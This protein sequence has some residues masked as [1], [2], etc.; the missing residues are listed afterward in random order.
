MERTDLEQWR[1]KE[2]ARL[3]ALVETERRYYQEMV[4]TLPVPLVV[5]AADNSIVSANRSFR[6]TFGFRTDDLRNKRIGELVPVEGI[7]EKIREAHAQGSAPPVFPGRLGERVLRVAVV[8][9]RNWDD[10]S[11]VE[12]LL[13]L[14][15]VSG[16]PGVAAAPAAAGPAP[17]LP[18]DSPAVFW[19]ADAETL[20]FRSVAGA[21]E[22]LF[23]FPPAH[24]TEE[25]GFFE[26]R[27]IAEDRAPVMALYR[28]IL[29]SGGEA[30]AE[31][32][33]ITSAGPAVWCRETI[34]VSAPAESPRSI[35]GVITDIGRRKELERQILS[36]G[37]LEALQNLAGRLAHDLNNPLM[38][39]TGYGEEMLHALQP[40]DPLRGDVT[41]ILAATERI[42]GITG[43]L[44]EIGR[45]HANPPVPVNIGT[46]MS[47]LEAQIALAAG[48]GVA[49][50]LAGGETAL[51]AYADGAQLGE[52]LL[53]LVSGAR[54]GAQG[55]TRVSVSW[56]TEVIAERVASATL[57]PG[58]YACISIHDDG[59][60]LD[61]R[62]SAVLFETVLPA[63]DAA[64]AG[65]ALAR[66]Y[67]LV[68]EWGGDIAL[69]TEPQRGTTFAVYLPHYEP[70]APAV[71]EEAAVTPVEP[72]KPVEA[73]PKQE[74]LRETILV[75]DDEA[76]IRGLVRKILARE[77]YRVLE[78][79]N[80]E[81]ALTI[82]VAQETPINLLLTDVVLPGMSGPDLARRMYEASPG[83][84]VL[85]ISGY[86][87][88]ETVRSGEFPPGA[89]FL[90][91]PFTLTALVN[92]V[93]ET[94][95]AK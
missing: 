40:D 60:G 34:R 92:K 36:A 9:I 57:A 91:K 25:A 16:F 6:Q 56:R 75:V 87:D 14:E 58:K 63:K 15:D 61:A 67:A 30:S 88:D 35:T 22:Q 62:H 83:L 41:E 10:E 33:A 47:S 32:R 23:G 74:P 37:R 73:A 49:V 82:S 93:R 1:S 44:I 59:P 84:R 38:I 94:L 29:T 21:V 4:A 90:A 69:A 80:A 79:G 5:L 46:L 28:S 31:F 54:D 39:V 42:S 26:Q 18:S 81:E 2:V 24:W 43:Q 13:M 52:A 45:R 68:L 27:I 55:R 19:Q 12:T 86:T 85:Y 8:P 95:D 76:G 3:L 72:E 11:Q 50:E 64:S 77:R 48:D 7:E 53:T 51:W 66:A 89:G 70:P 17:L 20:A 65:P 71:T 78:A